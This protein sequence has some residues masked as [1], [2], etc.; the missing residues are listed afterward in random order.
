MTLIILG[1]LFLIIYL[2]HKL[3]FEPLSFW[4]K[5]FSYQMVPE[6]ETAQHSIIL[7]KIKDFF[8]FFRLYA[9]FKLIKTTIQRLE[10]PLTRTGSRLI[11]L[12]SSLRHFFLSF[13]TLVFLILLFAFIYSRQ[14]FFASLFNQPFPLDFLLLSLLAVVT[15]FIRIAMVYL[16]CLAISY[17]LAIFL[18]LN[19]KAYRKITPFLQMTA[20][21]PGTA[22]YPL[23]LSLVL[24]NKIPLGL[25]IAAAIVIL[26]TSLWY[27]F[28]PLLGLMKNIPQEIKESVASLSTSRWFLAKKVLIPGSFPA[29]VT[30][31]LAA[32]GG[33]WNALVVAEYGVFGGK[34]YNVFGIGALLDQANYQDGDPIKI[35]ITLT[36]LVL[37]IIVL[38]KLVWQNLYRLAAKRFS[39]EIE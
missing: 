4:A 6:G 3:F 1:N 28:F 9:F 32:W 11:R 8:L 22:I 16:I 29:L 26:S 10:K 2:L 12:A 19:E 13:L 15:S 18:V 24:A 37:T 25:E 5:K 23:M 30:G 38:N 14:G 33:A 20:S 34:V 21:I 17:P 35:G 31:S 7:S 36:V 27:V 39:L